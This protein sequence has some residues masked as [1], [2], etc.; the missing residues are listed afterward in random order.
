M[1]TRVG[2]CLEWQGAINGWG[3]GS[4]VMNGHKRSASK[5]AWELTN[6]PVPDGLLVCHTCDNRRCV[7]PAHLFLGTPADNS[8]DMA[9]KGRNRGF[10][11]PGTPSPSLRFTD[12]QVRSM[13]QLR[14]EGLSYEKIGKRF[15]AFPMVVYRIVNRRQRKDVA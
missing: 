5:V 14:S 12:D 9:A 13:R 7:D 11:S 6:G 2:S 1:S 10:G 8:R 4:L 15:D 3:Y